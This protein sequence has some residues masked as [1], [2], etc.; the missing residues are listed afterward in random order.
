MSVAVD[1]ASWV[2]LAA[3]GLCCLIG[4]FGMLRMP[5]FYTRLHA[6]SLSDALGAG[7]ILLGLLLQAGWTLVAVKLVVVGLLLFLTS[8]A[9]T[10]A[11]AKAALERGLEPLLAQG[12]P[13][14][15]P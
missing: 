13:P 8:P 1:V 9:A 2:L 3:G 14:S 5:D 7:F 12:E 15:K 11:I 6:A 10:H 4:A